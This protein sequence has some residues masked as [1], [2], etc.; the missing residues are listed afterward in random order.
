MPYMCKSR[1]SSETK[2]MKT[3]DIHVGKL[4]LYTIQNMVY[5]FIAY[6]YFIF[7]ALFNG[8]SSLR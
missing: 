4:M 6:G 8:Y 5:I 2:S 3:L 7:L 1:S